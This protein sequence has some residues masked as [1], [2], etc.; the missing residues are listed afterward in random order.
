MGGEIGFLQVLKELFQHDGGEA[1]AVEVDAGFVQQDDGAGTDLGFQSAEDFCGIAFGAVETA[2]VP[3]GEGQVVLLEDRMDK[4]IFE[5]GRGAEVAGRTV[6]TK[7]GE[8]VLT[9]ADFL[10]EPGRRIDPEPELRMGVG[11]V[12]EGVAAADYFADQFGMLLG[13]D[14]DKKERGFGLMR[15]QQVE[16]QGRVAGIGSVVDGDPDGVGVGG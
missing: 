1:V 4:R 13:F 14:S 16:Q 5:S 10:L 8:D 11:V 15:V 9:A 2:G 3:T 6:G 12:A 7:V